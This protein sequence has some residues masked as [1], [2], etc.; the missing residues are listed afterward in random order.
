MGIA[1]RSGYEATTG[2]PGGSPAGGLIPPET[3]SCLNSDT[4]RGN[5]GRAGRGSAGLQNL[6]QD[7]DVEAGACF[8][9]L[10]LVRS[11]RPNWPNSQLTST[12]RIPRPFEGP[13]D[14]E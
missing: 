4:A 6:V 9:P 14:S 5:A 13:G 8:R 11:T 7:S 1:H 2:L 10:S 3:R 12:G